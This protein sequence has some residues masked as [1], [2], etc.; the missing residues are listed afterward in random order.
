MTKDLIFVSSILEDIK[1]AGLIIGVNPAS[2][3]FL[4]IF[5]RTNPTNSNLTTS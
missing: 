1:K 5:N 4:K 2:D 3:I